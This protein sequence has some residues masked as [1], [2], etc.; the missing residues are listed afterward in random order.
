MLKLY[1]TVVIK[2]TGKN[3]VIIEIDD[4]K[5]TKPPIYLVELVDKPLGASVADVVFWCDYSEIIP[6]TNS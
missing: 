4:D 2:S 3:A 1:D 5:G 6:N